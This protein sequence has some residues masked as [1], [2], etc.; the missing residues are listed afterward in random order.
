RGQ[1]AE[2]IATLERE[3]ELATVPETRAALL[4][5]LA[6]LHEEAGALERAIAAYR[7]AL[8]ALPG[9]LP[10]LAALERLHRARGDHAALVG[11]LQ[12]MA[13]VAR[14]PLDK[15]TALHRAGQV[16]EE[17]LGD[18][19]GAADADAHALAVVSGHAPSLEALERRFASS[20][21]WTELADVRRRA[22][23]AA[24]DDAARIA[25]LCAL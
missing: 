18:D 23:L 20:E 15:A 19:A 8:E 24:V 25:A 2:V 22:A 13:D 12:T 11:V 21:Q 1:T 14:E 9:H 7:A 3:V 6:E 16:R 4:D 5:R 10:A 17:R